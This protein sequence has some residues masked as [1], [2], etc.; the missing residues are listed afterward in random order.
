MTLSTPLIPDKTEF[1]RNVEKLSNLPTL[2]HLMTRFT[3]MVKDPNISMAAIGDELSKDHAT[4]SKLLRLVNSAFYGFPGRISTVTNA[5]VLLGFDAVKGL[6]M[7]SN[8]FDNLH[9]AAYPLWRHSLAVSLTCRKI[10]TVLD[11]DDLEE[12]TVAGLLHDIGKVI[13]HLEAPE[14]YEQVLQYA[15]EQNKQVWQAEQEMLGFDHASI[16]EWLCA[17]WLLPDKLGA[18]ITYHHQPSMAKQFPDRVAVVTIADAIVRGIGGGAEV[19]QPL[20][21]LD[22]VVLRQVSLKRPQLEDI[23]DKMLPEIEGLQLL[24][25]KDLK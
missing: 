20:E 9:P 12:I 4:T 17:K 13:L 11:M 14:A 5:L 8:V 25:P 3:E 10:G 21:R 16:G 22:P 6:I 15:T 7:T 24:G 18:P 19:D 23:V 2:P 1:R